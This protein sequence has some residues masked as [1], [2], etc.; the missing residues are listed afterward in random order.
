MANEFYTLIIVPHAKARFRRIQ[1]PVKFMKW[2]AGIAGSLTLLLIGILIHYTRISVQ[3]HELKRLRAENQSL[4]AKTQE[5]EQNA[6]KL[7][8]K[9]ELLQGMVTKLGVMAGLEQSLP[10]GQVGG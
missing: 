8:S 1:V 3:V 6:G 10:D 5:Y 7:Q 4:F 2:A 9:V